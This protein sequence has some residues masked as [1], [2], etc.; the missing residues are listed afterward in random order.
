MKFYSVKNLA[1]L[2]GASVVLAQLY[3][4][5]PRYTSQQ[6]QKNTHYAAF[7]QKAMVYFADTQLAD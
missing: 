4:D 7:L 5:G 2:A 1:K 6:G 3:V